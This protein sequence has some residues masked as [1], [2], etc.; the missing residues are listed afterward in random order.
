MI[1]VGISYIP[2]I[3]LSIIFVRKMKTREIIFENVKHWENYSFDSS[4][5]PFPCFPARYSFP[6]SRMNL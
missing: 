4:I 3:I 2:R 5:L 6:L 1:A